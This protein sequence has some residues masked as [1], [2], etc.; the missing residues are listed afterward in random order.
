MGIAGMN[1]VKGS[2]TGTESS[3]RP[4]RSGPARG[5][6]A[7]STSGPG[8]HHRRPR[9][10]GP[11]ARPGEERRAGGPGPTAPS[12]VPRGV[13]QCRAPR[14]RLRVL[15]GR[16]GLGQASLRHNAAAS[17][18][19]PASRVPQSQG[20]VRPP[21]PPPP[22]PDPPPPPPPPG[23]ARGS[24]R[25][26]PS[27][28]P[29]PGSRRAGEPGLRLPALAGPGG[30]GPR[31]RPRPPAEPA[32]PH[33]LLGGGGRPTAISLAARPGPARGVVA[34]TPP[35]V[36]PVP[37]EL[38]DELN[39]LEV[40]VDGKLNMSRQVDMI[41]LSSIHRGISQKYVTIFLLLR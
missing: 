20:H 31:P 7:G 2:S 30:A 37:Q 13:T 41:R 9:A 35:Q 36:S 33:E 23:A 12:P 19:S 38:K 28:P 16:A 3:S 32:R 34:P 29:R 6:G 15:P 27:Q 40:M 5:S 26:R 4:P 17:L 1:R 21:L 24:R 22:G 14:R 39:D 18:H 8:S 10:P 11:G 25:R